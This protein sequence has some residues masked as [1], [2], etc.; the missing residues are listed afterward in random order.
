MRELRT[1]LAGVHLSFLQS[2]DCRNDSPLTPALSPLRGEGETLTA[3]L[4]AVLK[5]GGEN[6]LRL[7]WGLRLPEGEGR[8]EGEVRTVRLKRCKKDSR[9]AQNGKSRFVGGTS[10][11][12]PH[13][14]LENAG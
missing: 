4:G 9:V 14:L 12:S 7:P 8:G 13:F 2:H 11:V 5:P 10:S 6:D 1:V 3:L